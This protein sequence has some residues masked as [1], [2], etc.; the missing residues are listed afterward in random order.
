MKK[1]RLTSVVLIVTIL[2]VS[3][4]SGTVSAQKNDTLSFLHIS[5][6]HLIFDI[7]TFQKDLAQSRSSCGNG[8]KSFKEFLKNAPRKTGSDFIV[9]TG[10]LVDIYEGEM[11][12]GGKSDTQIKQFTRLINKSKVPV[13]LTLGNHDITSYSWKDSSRVSTQNCVERARAAWIKSSSCFNSGVYYSKIVEVGA[14][15]YRLIFLNNAYNSLPEELNIE[16]PYID[17][18][19]LCWLEDQ[20][21]QSEDD[22]EIILMHLPLTTMSE[23][24]K[25]SS[26]LYFVLAKYPSV[27]LIFAGHNHRNAIKNFP[28]VENN[29]ITQV[30]TGGFGQNNENWRMIELTEDK[31][32][33]SQPGTTKKE[34]D[35]VLNKN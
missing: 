2:I 16:L 14:T 30:Q 25:P 21:Q 26:D 27:K 15:K 32:L 33:V 34:I 29:K 13:Y 35:I 24:A 8:I 10:D 7:E 19:Q 3:S 22:V 4:I 6:I 11:A 12:N 17:K 5:D 28:S 18:P 20:I 9:A 1:N 23:K 31:I